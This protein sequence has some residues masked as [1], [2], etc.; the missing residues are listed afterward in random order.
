MLVG[1]P[2]PAAKEL[3]GPDAEL[4]VQVVQEMRGAFTIERGPV[5]GTRI[6]LRPGLGRQT[7]PLPSPQPWVMLV[8]GAR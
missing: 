3:A 6:L 2:D 8:A 5:E 7:V 4:M 1:R